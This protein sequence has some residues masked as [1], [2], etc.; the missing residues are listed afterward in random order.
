M[1]D[2]IQKQISKHSFG[3]ALCQQDKQMC[4]QD[5]AFW[6]SNLIKG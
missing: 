2:K 5:A 6:W 1:F 4:S 3:K